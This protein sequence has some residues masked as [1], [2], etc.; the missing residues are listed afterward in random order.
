[1]TRLVSKRN[2]EILSLASSYRKQVSTLYKSIAKPATYIEQSQQ[3]AHHFDTLRD[4]SQ[5]SQSFEPVQEMVRQKKVDKATFLYPALTLLPVVDPIPT[6]VL[7]LG[8][9]ICIDNIL[10]DL[11]PARAWQAEPTDVFPKSIAC[12]EQLQTPDRQMFV[13]LSIVDSEWM[14]P[15]S[16]NEE[17]AK[18]QMKR[19]DW[20]VGRGRHAK[21]RVEWLEL[22]KN[23]VLWNI[24]KPGQGSDRE[25]LGEE[26]NRAHHST[27]S[28]Y[29]RYFSCF[30][31]HKQPIKDW[32]VSR[33]ELVD[34]G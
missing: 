5:D 6:G 2:A 4:P 17:V 8:R 34:V 13:S 28:G 11:T 24:K 30:R 31:T 25:R 19:P 21:N 1:M 32:A 27:K 33:V 9:Q 18:R 12:R 15:L 16:I 7:D 22:V 14:L 10:V 29:S 26:Y 20:R 3:A 23:G